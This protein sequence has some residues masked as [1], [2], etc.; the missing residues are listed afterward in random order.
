MKKT[1]LLIC[2]LFSAKF[3]L[4]QSAK[5]ILKLKT[6]RQLQSMVDASPFLTG[7]MAVDLTTG[8]SFSINQDIVFAQASAI[9]IPILLEVYKQ[10]RE[11]KFA[12]TDTRPLLL[13]NTVAGSGILNA[14]ADPV[15][16]SIRNYC[17]LMIGL[18]DNSATNTLIDLVGMQNINSTMKTLGLK[19]TRVQRKMIDQPASLRNEENISTPAEAVKILKLLYDGKFIDKAASDEILLTLQKNPV[20]NSKIAR[21][22]P[23][24]VKIAFKPGGMGGVSTEWGLVYLAK[25]PYAVAIMENY[26]AGSAS[27]DSIANI[28][29]TLYEYYSRMAKATNYGVILE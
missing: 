2:L 6:E 16:L 8:D 3:L 17:M 19:N 28:S 23:S 18:S 12:L 21:G 27:P 29:K 20:E 14:M 1:I 7:L 9:K 5:D 10:A 24:S 22:I 11:N 13:A 4:A 15:S 25:K 26:K